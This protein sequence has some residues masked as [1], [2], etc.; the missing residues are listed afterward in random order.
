ME[1]CFALAQG[2]YTLSPRKL[3]GVICDAKRVNAL[4]VWTN[5]PRDWVVLSSGLLMA[6]REAAEAAAGQLSLRRKY[7]GTA[8][9]RDIGEQSPMSGG[10]LCSLSSLLNI[11]ALSFVV[12]H[13]I[14]HHVEGH[15]GYY[16]A[17]SVAEVMESGSARGLEQQA[18]ELHAHISG[19]SRAREVVIR[20]LS[21]FLDVSAY[22]PAQRS[23]SSRVLALIIYT[24]TCLSLAVLR[25]KKADLSDA[26]LAKISHPPAAVRALWISSQ[27]STSIKTS[28]AALSELEQ[29]WIRVLSMELAAE[30]TLRRGSPEH[31][32]Y[33]RRKSRR[34]PAALR[35]VGIRGMVHDGQ[36][37]PYMQKLLRIS[38]ALQPRLRPRATTDLR[39]LAARARVSPPGTCYRHPQA[40]VI[41]SCV[42]AASSRG[43]PMR[44]PRLAAST[45]V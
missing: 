37:E 45:C 7:V 23:E 42:K 8:L 6:V 11:G 1:L 25:P 29:R 16:T 20:F 43:K 32:L 19:T 13:E 4:A 14:G 12:G 9:A 18:L 24:S 41:N 40:P 31:E 21:H 3:A 15:D 36:L 34:E 39:R 10:F 33:L 38:K 5:A 22:S 27:L 30:A 28:F 17:G 44:A 2:S 35:A 26:A